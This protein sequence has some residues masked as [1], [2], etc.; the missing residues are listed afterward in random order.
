M[1]LSVLLKAALL[2]LSLSACVAPLLTMGPGQLMW[3]MLKPMVGLDPNTT[4][5]F[6]QPVIKTRMTSLL[7]PHYDTTVSLL[8]TAGELQQEGPLFYLVSRTA[9]QT[10]A[11]K[12]GLVWN[13][14]SNQMS[15]LLSANDQT[16]VFSESHTGKA[17][18]WPDEMQG[19]LTKAAQQPAPPLGGA[20]L[21]APATAPAAAP[22]QNELDAT[23]TQLQQTEEKLKALE[24]QQAKAAADKPS[25]PSS[26]EPKTLSREQRE[27]AME[28]ML[29]E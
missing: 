19:W 12:A 7:G 9:E 26:S 14:D 24:N 17:A 18:V 8:R 25:T 6:E 16:R 27:A 13:A 21:A 2:S 1:R 23:R 4:N 5:L 15:V 3:A 22:L 11:D 20:L 28:A 10:G 29:S